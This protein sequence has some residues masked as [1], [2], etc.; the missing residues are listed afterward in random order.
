MSVGYL[1]GLWL[2]RINMNNIDSREMKITWEQC[3]E[4]GENDFLWPLTW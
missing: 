2:L 3:W 1:A 4:M